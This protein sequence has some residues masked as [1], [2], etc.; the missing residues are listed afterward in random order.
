MNVLEKI[1][2]AT[3]KESKLAHEEMRR[4]ASENHLQFDEIK[5]YARACETILEIIHSY[6]DEAANMS[7]K[8]LIDAN[9]LDDEVMNFFLA[10]TGNPKQTT[11]VREC[12]E[13]FRRMIDEQL[14]IYVDDGW[15]PVSERLPEPF[16][17][18]EVTVHCSE[19]ISDYNSVW[20]PEN[21][22][23]HHDE[24]YLSRI[25][26]TDEGGDWLFYDKDG[27]EIYYDKE[28]GSD[29]TDVYNVVTAWRPLPE[30]YKGGE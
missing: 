15:I 14:T 28:F 7:G 16:K 21:E 23:I 3:E 17:L 27:C 22:K 5:G 4:C 20:I 8:R 26:Y 2:E 29:K 12:K 13:S 24:E 10:I 11:V 9:A 1:L 18:V 30:P 25:G 6:I 19:W